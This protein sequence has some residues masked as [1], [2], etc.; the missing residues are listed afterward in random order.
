[1]NRQL[2]EHEFVPVHLSLITFDGRLTLRDDEDHITRCV[3]QARGDVVQAL[4]DPRAARVPEDV[5]PW[6]QLQVAFYSLA[7]RR[8]HLFLADDRGDD[9]ASFKMA[10]DDE[11]AAPWEDWYRME[12]MM[13]DLLNAAHRDGHDVVFSSTAPRSTSCA[14]RDPERQ[15][16][17]TEC[18]RVVLLSRKRRGVA[19][20]HTAGERVRPAGS[21]QRRDDEWRLPAGALGAARARIRP[22]RSISC[23]GA[24][25]V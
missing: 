22:A 16:P 5:H 19:A 25:S 21:A 9:L 7:D 8:L 15:R 6:V 3:T 17:C 12:P 23:S 2:L 13:L 14:H 11:P 1:M 24:T 18:L 10:P 20:S 4:C